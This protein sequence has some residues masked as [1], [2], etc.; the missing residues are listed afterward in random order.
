S[1][2]A[3]EKIL[4]K[5]VSR[6]YPRMS[7]ATR[8]QYRHVVENI[9]KRTEMSEEDIASAALGLSAVSGKDASS[10]MSHIGYYLTGD[11]RYVLERET[12]YVPPSGERLY[13][14]TQRK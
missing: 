13:R 8:D 3:T 6:D 1:Q 9:A 14:W 10:R 4:R 2:S 11:G 5:D 7:F 12:G